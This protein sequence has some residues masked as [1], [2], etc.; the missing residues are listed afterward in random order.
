MTIEKVTLAEGRVKLCRGDCFAILPGLE[1]V[2]ACITDPP[3]CS[4]G[5]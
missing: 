2:A 3:Y 1:Q 4:G 5:Q